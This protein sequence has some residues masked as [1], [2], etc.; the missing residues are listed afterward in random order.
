LRICALGQAQ[1][2][3][4]GEQRKRRHRKQGPKF[5]HAFHAVSE[6][7][8]LDGTLC[9]AKRRKKIPQTP[10]I[11]NDYLYQH[12]C[13]CDATPRKVEAIDPLA[14]CAA[15]CVRLTDN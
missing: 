12:P 15:P 5:A 10:Q 13:I 7:H 11:F 8:S 2:A 14:F 1:P 6:E 9:L 3:E 4:R